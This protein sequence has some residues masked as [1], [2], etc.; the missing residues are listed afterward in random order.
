MDIR[1]QVN[2]RRRGYGEKQ[3][4]DR[5]GQIFRLPRERAAAMSDTAQKDCCI[6]MGKAV[7]ERAIRGRTDGRI[8]NQNRLRYGMGVSK[9]L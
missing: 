7:K 3:K 6:G 8:R 5:F 2:C 4:D 1:L 9:E